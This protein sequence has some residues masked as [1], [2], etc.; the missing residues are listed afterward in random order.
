MVSAQASY[1]GAGGGASAS[2][3]ELLIILG[4]LGLGGFLAYEAAKPKEG[5][6]WFFDVKCQAEKYALDAGKSVGGAINYVTNTY[7]A[8]AG[9]AGAQAATALSNFATGNQ[10]QYGN[11]AML[12]IWNAQGEQSTYANTT[13]VIGGTGGLTNN[14]GVDEGDRLGLP[15]GVSPVQFCISSPSSPICQQVQIPWY[16]SIPLVGGLI[17]A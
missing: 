15:S 5:E 12:P 6:C 9:A 17:P 1:M 7:N 13:W 8:T 4:V 16:K 10:V 14:T 2:T 11:T 3:K